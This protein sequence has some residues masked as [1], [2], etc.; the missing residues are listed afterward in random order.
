MMVRIFVRI[1]R[2]IFILVMVRMFMVKMILWKRV[3]MVLGV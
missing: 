3:I 1:G 2:L